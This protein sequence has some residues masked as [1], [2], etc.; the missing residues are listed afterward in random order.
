MR[1]TNPWAAAALAYV[2]ARATGTPL[3][4]SLRITLNFHPDRAARGGGTTLDAIARSG[5]YLSQFATGTSAGRLTA[6]PGGARWLWEHR[7]FGGAY[8]DAPPDHRPT[9]GALNHRSHPLGGAPRFGSS[10]LRLA[11]ATLDRATFCFPDS[12]FEPERLAT[13]QRC[14]LLPL[15]DA[16]AAT[17]RDDATE[18]LEGGRLDAYVEAHIH[19][20][21]TLEEDV[22]AIVLDPSF[23]GTA[24][25]ETASSLGIPV[26]WHEGRVLTVAELQRHPNFRGAA[27]VTLGTDIAHDG[28]LDA[29]TIGEAART[30][31]PQL[32]KYVWHLTARFGTPVP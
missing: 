23:R 14:D 20:G 18:K 22:E 32:L 4:R 3:D 5:R 2:A 12:V 16:F 21:V 7:L 19:G 8:D 10:H 15:A 26:E 11:E 25:E 30:H 9:Y 13:A 29:R 27:A 1:G 6:H 24:V 17:P 28:L 31:D